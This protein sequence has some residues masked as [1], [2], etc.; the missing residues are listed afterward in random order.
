MAE[1]RVPL[2]D[3]DYAELRRLA[4]ENGLTLT[5][6]VRMLLLRMLRKPT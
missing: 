2:S 4:K 5:G 1:L 3:D 6:Y